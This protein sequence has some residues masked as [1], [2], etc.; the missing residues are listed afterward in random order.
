MPYTVGSSA[1]HAG[2]I[3]LS[4]THTSNRDV[5]LLHPAAHLGRG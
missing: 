3:T 4:L 2:D 5:Q 1:C